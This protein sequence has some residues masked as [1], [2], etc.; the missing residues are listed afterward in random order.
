MPQQKDASGLKEEFF[1]IPGTYLKDDSVL[2][3]ENTSIAVKA[4]MKKDG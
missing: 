3:R 2:I 4:M 1:H